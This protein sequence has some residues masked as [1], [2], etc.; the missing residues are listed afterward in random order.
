M[1]FSKNFFIDSVENSF[2]SSN[3]AF[4]KVMNITIRTIIQYKCLY[5]IFQEA[6]LKLMWKIS[7]IAFTFIL[8]RLKMQVIDEKTPN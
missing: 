2:N 7:L 1:K 3:V 8:H 4:K 6:F 5:K